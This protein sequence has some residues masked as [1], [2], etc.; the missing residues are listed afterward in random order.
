ML[1][2]PIY[3]VHDRRPKAVSLAPCAHYGSFGEVVEKSLGAE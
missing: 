3:F 2:L 1:Y